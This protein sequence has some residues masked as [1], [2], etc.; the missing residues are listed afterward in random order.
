MGKFSQLVALTLCML[1]A[2]GCPDRKPAVDKTAETA[3]ARISEIAASQPQNKQAPSPASVEGTHPIDQVPQG[4]RF[5]QAA[6]AVDRGDF[7]EAERIGS[8]LEADSQYNVLSSA[9]Q[10]L[11]LVKKGH[12]DEALRIAEEISTVPVMQSEAYVI[13]GQVFQRQNRLNE[14]LD[15][16]QNSLRLNPQHLRANLWLGAIYYD[17]GAMRLAT[18]HLRKAAELDPSEVNSLLLSAK[19]FKEYEQF[20]EAIRDYRE[21]LTRSLKNDAQLLVRIS[22]TECLIALR[23]LPE[24]R[25]T[26]Q[27]C[28]ESPRVLATRSAIEELAG[29][30]S[31]ALKLAQS[32]LQQLPLDRAAGLIAGR[33]LL[34]QR[35]WNEALPLLERLT[36]SLPYDHE[37][38]LLYGRA[39]VGSGDVVGGEKEIEKATQ[40]KDTFLKFAD[41]HQEAIKR[42]QDASLR[43]EI[44]RLAEQL[45][46]LELARNWYRA[47]LGLDQQNSD[48]EAALKRMSSIP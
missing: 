21:L 8:E 3:K 44:G 37:P 26:L 7:N 23:D 48:A 16:F 29:D 30:N 19:I 32:V 35:D 11:I 25:I 22:L 24:A 31:A 27:D 20:D 15:A 45:G 42:P 5:R 10:G 43:V 33:I 12:L 14:A 34:V 4:K 6:A 40:L 39:L 18:N 47:A 2:S 28:A 17:T 1:A 13:A 9:I 36:K 41:L 46:K 38:R